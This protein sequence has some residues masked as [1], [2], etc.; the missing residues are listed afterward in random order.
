MNDGIDDTRAQV[1][2][3]R[4][5]RAQ[6]ATPARSGASYGFRRDVDHEAFAQ[7]ATNEFE[8]LF[9][10]HR[11]R[12][13][14]KWHHY[15]EIYDRHLSW[16]LAGRRARNETQPVRL[17]EIGVSGGG[18]LQMW[19]KYFG[20]EA[21]IFGVDVNPRCRG[22]ADPDVEV[23]IGS[24]AD[25]AFMR[26]VVDEMGGIDIVLDDGS[27]VA[28]HQI[29][30]FDVLFPRLSESGLYIC[31]DLHTAY[32]P[33]YDG[34]LSREG[35]FLEFTK[36]MLDWL[37]DWYVT[38]QDREDRRHE[39]TYGFATGVFGVSV[40]DSM[41]VIEKRRRDRP[42]HTVVGG[43]EKLRARQSSANGTKTP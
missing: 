15:L 21:V 33:K 2:S 7:Q 14:H 16:F 32:M 18:S 9:Y 8:R 40:Y 39:D 24:Q 22:S 43:D 26:S 6:N 12:R 37:H 19:R 27:H 20:P 4:P 34:G 29:A 3:Q 38:K 41:A 1:P 10:S 31:E 5:A 28:S 30:S 13:L 23:R 42:F 17:L 25:K 36:Q 11:G 35:T